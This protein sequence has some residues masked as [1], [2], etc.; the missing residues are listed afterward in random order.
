MNVC[1]SPIRLLSPLYYRHRLESYIRDILWYDGRG[2]SNAN[3][4]ISVS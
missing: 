4:V 2:L 3:T 1:V